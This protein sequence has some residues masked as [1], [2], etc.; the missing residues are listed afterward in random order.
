MYASCPVSLESSYLEDGTGGK[1]TR[2]VHVTNVIIINTVKMKSPPP[3]GTEFEH[4]VNHLSC[5]TLIKQTKFLDPVT[6]VDNPARFPG[7][8]FQTLSQSAAE[9]SS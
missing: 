4:T 3:A 1:Q 2:C 9:G 7:F 6:V 5:H 8:C